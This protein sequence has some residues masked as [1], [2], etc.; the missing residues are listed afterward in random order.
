MEWTEIATLVATVVV[1][2]GIAAFGGP[3]LWRT[4]KAQGEASKE[5]DQA[6][7]KAIATQGQAMEKNLREAIAAQGQASRER[8]QALEKNLRDAIAAQGQAS[9]ERDEA[10][11][12]TIQAQGEAS[13]DRDHA[14]DKRLDDLRDDLRADDRTRAPYRV[15]RAV[16]E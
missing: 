3:W 14:I 2:G 12:K 13:K 7:E 9:R 4:I 5:R 15:A 1:P 8:D 10:L 6:L 16:S 11:E